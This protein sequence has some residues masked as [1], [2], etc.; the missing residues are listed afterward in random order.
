MARKIKVSAS[1]LNIR[2]HP[3]APETYVAWLDAIYRKKLIAP[4]FGDRHGMISSLNRSRAEDGVLTGVITTFVKFDAAAD[5]FN[6]DNLEEATVD[7]VSQINI[8]KN[9]HYNPAQFFFTFQARTHRF[10]FQTYSKGKTLTPLS[11]KNF[12]SYLSRNLDVLERFGEAQISVVQEKATL[13]KMFK[14]DRIKEISITILKP[15]TDIFDDDF[16]Q[17]IEAHLAKT[18]SRQLTVTYKAD[19]NGSIDPDDDI[20]KIS[21][22][23]LHNGSVKV[24]GRDEKGAVTLNSENF[25]E[26]YHDRY[27]PD[28]QTERSAFDSLLPIIAPMAR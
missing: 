2:L 8:P 20:K 9:M 7:D 13:D 18:K 16:E 21:D 1:A 5:W 6:S 25:P 15:N 14:I 12:M 22:V 10:Y 3:H 27:D 24:V 23:A 4:V 11:A 19:A 26:E 17:N 28:A